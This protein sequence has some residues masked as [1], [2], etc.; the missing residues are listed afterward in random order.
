MSKKQTLRTPTGRDVDNIAALII[1][2]K[3]P[4]DAESKVALF[5]R[6]A[7]IVFTPETKKVTV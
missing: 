1:A 4:E 7:G 3:N 2:S 5:C 6:V